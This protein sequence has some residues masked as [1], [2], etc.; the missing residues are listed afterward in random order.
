MGVGGFQ[1]LRTS[2]PEKKEDHEE[3]GRKKRRGHS[4]LDEEVTEFGETH[5]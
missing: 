3:V 5:F 4:I 2:E 1:E